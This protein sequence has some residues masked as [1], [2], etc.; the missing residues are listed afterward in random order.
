MVSVLV[1]KP[2]HQG[3]DPG[4]KT[5]DPRSQSQ[6]LDTNQGLGLGLQFLKRSGQQHCSVAD[7]TVC[8]T[9]YVVI[10]PSVLRMFQLTT[11]RRS[12]L[13]KY[14]RIQHITAF[15]KDV[16]RKLIY[17]L[18]YLITWFHTATVN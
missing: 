11:K 1:T 8:Q 7:P 5:V 2:W 12:F 15:Y 9:T 18:T 4:V 3:L 6:D 17:L 13:P 10:P 14:Q 16:L